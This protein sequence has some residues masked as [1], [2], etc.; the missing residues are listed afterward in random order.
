MSRIILALAVFVAALVLVPLSLAWGEGHQP[1]TICHK[2]G[3]P[4]EQTLTVDDDAVPGHLGHGDYLG[5]CKPSPLPADA[6]CNTTHQ[7]TS[8]MD[9]ET[10]ARMPVGRARPGG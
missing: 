7:Q 2:P 10:R 1:V 4:A 6:A 5:A 3:T 8:D 9:C